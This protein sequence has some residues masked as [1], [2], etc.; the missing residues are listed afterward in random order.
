MPILVVVLESTGIKTQRER[1]KEVRE[2]KN[3]RMRTHTHRERKCV[4]VSVREAECP[5]I[6][7]HERE[8]KNAKYLCKAL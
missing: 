5:K 4:F 7:S 2:K 3:L 6:K 8:T 1:G